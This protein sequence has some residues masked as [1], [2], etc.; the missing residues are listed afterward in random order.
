VSNGQL[1]NL[2]AVRK[3][4]GAFVGLDDSSRR[5]CA[6]LFTTPL[7]PTASLYK[8]E[9]FLIRKSDLDP[10]LRSEIERLSHR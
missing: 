6:I 1:A 4:K 2:L 5:D 7:S 8:S 10:K 9:K 3:N